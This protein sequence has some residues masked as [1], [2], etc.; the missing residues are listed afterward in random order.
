MH[1]Q[2]TTA[3]LLARIAR[4][5]ADP[6]MHRLPVVGTTEDIRDVSP[7]ARMQLRAPGDGCFYLNLR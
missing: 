4:M 6:A 3:Q 2:L 7:D 1:T 5:K